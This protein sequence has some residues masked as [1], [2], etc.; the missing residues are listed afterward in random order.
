MRSVTLT[1]MTI[2]KTPKLAAI[3]AAIFCLTAPASAADIGQRMYTKAPPVTAAKSWTGFYVGANVGYAWLDS[4]TSFSPNDGASTFYTNFVGTPP[5]SFD[6]SGV[7]GGFQ[8]GYNWQVSD[9]W[10]LGL[11]ADLS[12]GDLKGSGASIA[13]IAV[14]AVPFSTVADSQIEW[15]STIRARLGYVATPDLLLFA[16]G[17]LAI[18]RVEQSARYN[19]LTGSSFISNAIDG[20]SVL[21]ASFSTCFAGASSDTNYGWTVGAGFEYALFGNFT[22]KAEYLYVRLEDNSFNVTATNSTAGFAPATFTAD[23]GRTDFH[24][25]R[26]GVNYRF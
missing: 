22:L 4:H 9:R 21:C 7:T 18:A 11:E 12:L 14:P 16:T 15:F 13:T 6:H 2:M 26:L 20:S 23:F 24:T 25:A 19:N 17:G 5:V 10:V 8:L 1:R 3:S